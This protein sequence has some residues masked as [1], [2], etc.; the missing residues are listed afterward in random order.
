VSRPPVNRKPFLDLDEAA[1][2][3]QSLGFAAANRDTVKYHAYETGR[4]PRPKRV[5][6]RGYWARTDLDAFVANLG[7][8]APREPQK[9][10]QRKRDKALRTLKAADEQL[11]RLGA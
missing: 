10:A 8:P 5:G 7:K 2:Y 1:I 3:L 9:A 11:Q 4:L 6:R